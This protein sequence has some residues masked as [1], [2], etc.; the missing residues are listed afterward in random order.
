MSKPGW[1]PSERGSTC[2][3]ALSSWHQFHYT[4]QVWWSGHSFG[5]FGGRSLSSLW[6]CWS[7][8]SNLMR[9]HQELKGRG[10][11]SSYPKEIHIEVD[12]WKPIHPKKIPVI[13]LIWFTLVQLILSN[14]LE[15]FFKWYLTMRDYSKYVCRTWVLIN[16]IQ[17][18]QCNFISIVPILLLLQKQCRFF[19]NNVLWTD[20]ILW[21]IEYFEKIFKKHFKNMKLC[22]PLNKT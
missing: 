16:E 18:K 7:C 4:A 17:S 10:S 2:L 5:E 3:T 6:H 20:N 8:M 1:K 9:A 13:K 14:I 21:L 12:N 22:N 15:S 11:Y 19:F